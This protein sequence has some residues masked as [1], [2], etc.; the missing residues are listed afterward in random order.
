[1][2]DASSNDAIDSIQPG[3]FK[4]VYGPVMHCLITTGSETK[5]DIVSNLIQDIDEVELLSSRDDIFVIAK[6]MFCERSNV[7]VDMSLKMRRG[8]TAINGIASD[9]HDMYSYVVNTDA[10]FPRDVLKQS[11][12]LLEVTAGDKDSESEVINQVA[13]GIAD[14]ALVSLT[15]EIQDLRGEVD[16][17][18]STITVLSL[19][20]EADRFR[21]ETRF[22]DIM[23]QLL[24]AGV[25]S[26]QQIADSGVLSEQQIA[27]AAIRKT[28]IAGGVRSEQHTAGDVIRE[29][30]TAGGVI[31]EQHTAGGVIREKQ[32]TGGVRNEQQTAGGV[33]R[34]QQTAGGVIREQQ[35][36]GGV[37]R[38]QQTAGGVRNEQQVDYVSNKTPVGDSSASRNHVTQKYVNQG[39]LLERGQ[40]GPSQ[41]QQRKQKTPDQT[42]SPEG[43]NTGTIEGSI[44]QH[45]VQPSTET[46][47]QARNTTSRDSQVSQTDNGHRVEGTG[48]TKTFADVTGAQGNYKW[49][50]VSHNR[51]NSRPNA[52]VNS[53]TADLKG[54]P[55]ERA[56]RV[57]LRNVYV[58]VG[59]TEADIKERVRKYAVSRGLR[60]MGI[61]IISNRYIEDV[62]GCKLLIPETQLSIALSNDFWPENTNC[63]V[64]FEKQNDN[65]RG[66]A[67]NAHTRDNYQNDNRSQHSG[68][69]YENN[70][71][72]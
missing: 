10:V 64:W 23:S 53:H 39:I 26:E 63:R 35:T 50:T 3:I 48:N 51:K 43:D 6:E 52:H 68:E 59:D 1:M 65:R 71:W 49:T 8:K 45:A 66:G 46:A 70:R 15:Q 28:Q 40:V 18:K 22:G 14:I 21:W 2:D 30:H 25:L 42:R 9:L 7:Q 60:I 58:D 31:R 11:S 38:E 27:G 56:K 16:T 54:V 17:L 57:Y 37:I 20:K 55:I 41:T 44:T 24:I 62:V 13:K 72:E 33:I 19:E 61:N 4:H 67:R 69:R 12:R 29:Q 36:A 47:G 34:E 5:A 32:I